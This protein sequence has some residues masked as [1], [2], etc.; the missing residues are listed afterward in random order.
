MFS[1][2]LAE[3]EKELETNELMLRFAA[4]RKKLAS[5]P[6]RPAYHFA[7][8][9]NM[10]NDPNGLCFWQ[11]RWHL[12]YQGY[13]PDEFPDPKDIKK[14]RQHWGHAVSDDFL[15]LARS[16]LRDLSWRGTHVLFRRHRVEEWQPRRGFYSGIAAGQMVAV[17][18]DPLLLNWDKLGPIECGVGD[19]DI[20]KEGNTYYGLV[21]GMAR[22]AGGRRLADDVSLVFHRSRSIGSPTAIFSIRLRS[23]GR[24][25]RLS[26]FPT[27]RRQTH[28]AVLQPQ[29]R[30]P[31]FPGRLRITS[32]SPMTMA[33]SITDASRRAASMLRPRHR[34]A[35]G[36]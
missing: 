34:M 12:F 23:R 9:E 35:R 24:R 27:H 1:E 33:G 21:G 31:I 20:W 17:A 30:R 26:E 32:L 29:Q 18:D 10:L 25:R 5:I 15:P 7:S 13:P 28:P 36:A 8:P 4:S 16:A 19:S 2:T 22:Y 14:R 3:Q 11:G 6:H